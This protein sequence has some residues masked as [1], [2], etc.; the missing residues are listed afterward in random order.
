[1]MGKKDYRAKKLPDPTLYNEG[2]SRP[3]NKSIPL[4]GLDPLA[5][6]EEA[7]VEGRPRS[8]QDSDIRAT[9]TIASQWE[10]V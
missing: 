7:K 8:I 5:K 4:R 2:S 9:T 10:A 3:F 6:A 1:M